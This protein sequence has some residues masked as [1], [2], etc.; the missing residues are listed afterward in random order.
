MLEQTEDDRARASAALFDEF[1]ERYDAWYEGPLGRLAF[2][3]EVDALRPL[4]AAL[5]GPRI[6]VGVGTGR[7]AAALGVEYGID[8]SAT[9]LTLARRRGITVV[10]A[11]GEALPFPDRTFGAVLLVVTLCF[12]DDPL[13]VLHETYRV[14]KPGGGVVLGLV[15]AESPWGQH[16]RALGRSGHPYY[17]LAHFFSHAEVVSTL[18]TAG[19]TLIR[20][21]SAL[22]QGPTEPLQ[23]EPAR[24]GFNDQDGFSAMLARPRR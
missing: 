24:D 11:R 21:R 20:E 14:L 9:A 17:R 4:V 22:F 7:F 13:A 16:Y 2:P 18:E 3:Q 5:P 12:V 6:E 23:I 10:Q 19:F 8:P 1:A 15:L